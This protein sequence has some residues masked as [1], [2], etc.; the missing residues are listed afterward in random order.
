MAEDKK[1]GSDEF[2]EGIPPAEPFDANAEVD[3]TDPELVPEV[4]SDPIGIPRSSAAVFAILAIVVVLA[5]ITAITVPGILNARREA[6]QRQTVQQL[7]SIGSSQLAYQSTNEGAIFGTFEILKSGA[8]I[9]D[10]AS[11]GD[12]IERY[13]L[14]WNVGNTPASSDNSEVTGRTYPGRF[15]VIAFPRNPALDQLSTFGISEDFVVR[16]YN[17]DSENDETD[18]KTWDPIL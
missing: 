5:I 13:S 1:K 3:P 6:S 12:M 18:V 11:L 15:T 7:R 2:F 17:P 9:P 14:S 4:P 8:Y 16:I 10:D